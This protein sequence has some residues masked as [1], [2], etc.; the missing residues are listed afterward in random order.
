MKAPEISRDS[1]INVE[2]LVVLKYCFWDVSIMARYL[3]WSAQRCDDYYYLGHQQGAVLDISINFKIIHDVSYGRLKRC[4][5][6]GQSLIVLDD[7]AGMAR[8][9]GNMAYHDWI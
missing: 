5:P 7:L 1:R 3:V 4:G 2:D 8:N 9:P 6:N